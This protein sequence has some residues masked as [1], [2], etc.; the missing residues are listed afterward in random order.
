MH[1]ILKLRYLL[2]IS[3]LLLPSP[4]YAADSH[5]QW[6][7]PI[8]LR[9]GDPTL[10]VSAG[11]S[12]GYRVGRFYWGISPEVSYLPAYNSIDGLISVPSVRLGLESR[13]YFAPEFKPW[14]G[15]GGGAMYYYANKYNDHRSVSVLGP[16][17]KLSLGATPWGKERTYGPYISVALGQYS[18]AWESGAQTTSPFGRSYGSASAGLEWLF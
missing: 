17:G 9:V 8:A 11:V 7:L 13:Y 5:V 14:I 4:I 15:L 10:A 18:Y 3:V 2:L 16:Y 6:S 1:L 12:V